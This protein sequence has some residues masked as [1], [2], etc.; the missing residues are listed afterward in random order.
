[1]PPGG[2]GSVAGDW[3]GGKE[4]WVNSALLESIDIVGLVTVM[5][6]I[7]FGWWWCSKKNMSKDPLLLILYYGKEWYMLSFI[8]TLSISIA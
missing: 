7:L 2:E 6:K 5:N 8:K 1:M 4:G 3:N